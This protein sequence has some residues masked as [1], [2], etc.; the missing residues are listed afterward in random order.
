MGVRTSGAGGLAN[1]FRTGHIR[2]PWPFDQRELSRRD[3]LSGAE[4]VVEEPIHITRTM[5]QHPAQLFGHGARTFAIAAAEQGR[6][7]RAVVRLAYITVVQ[8]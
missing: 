5:N 6:R 4:R 8:E 3:F 2:D 7:D 1:P